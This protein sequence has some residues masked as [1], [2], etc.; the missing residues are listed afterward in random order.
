MSVKNGHKSGYSEDCYTTIDESLSDLPS[1]NQ[2]LAHLVNSIQF[3][4]ILF[5]HTRLQLMLVN[6]IDIE[7]RHFTNLNYQ[8]SIIAEY[9]SGV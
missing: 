2:S 7:K 4:S 1:D 3:N 8:P 6:K 9:N 5:I